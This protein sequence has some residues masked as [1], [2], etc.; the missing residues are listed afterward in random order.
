MGDIPVSLWL[1][2][3]VLNVYFR[4]DTGFGGDFCNPT[5]SLPMSLNDDFESGFLD[6]IWPEIYGGDISSVCGDLV[7]GSSLSFY[8]VI[9]FVA[10]LLF[11]E[12]VFIS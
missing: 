3:L 5:K 2:V 10:F 4:C 12:H 1:K 7:S 6:E 9:F 8:K 11:L